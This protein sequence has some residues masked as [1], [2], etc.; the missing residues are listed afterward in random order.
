MIKKFF[1]KTFDN[2]DK[3]IIKIMKNGLKFCFL[4]LII[5]IFIL[6]TYLF[7]IHNNFIYQIGLIVFQLSLYFAADF[8]ISGLAIDT[9]RKQ[10]M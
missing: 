3:N 1:K 4:I 10:V 8:I 6:I 2:I 9:I 5:S 7:F